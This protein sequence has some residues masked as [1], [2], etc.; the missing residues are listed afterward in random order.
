MCVQSPPMYSKY[1]LLANQVT[2]NVLNVGTI[3]AFPIRLAQ[4]TSIVCTRDFTVWLQPFAIVLSCTFAAASLRPSK[5]T[6]HTQLNS[7]L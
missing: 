5:Y 4:P 2:K 3:K 7:S 6:K 1:L